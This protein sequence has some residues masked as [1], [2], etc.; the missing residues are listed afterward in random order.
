MRDY[1]N[2]GLFAKWLARALE[3]RGRVEE[4]RRW[5]AR[6]FLYFEL[7][8]VPD[9]V[10]GDRARFSALERGVTVFVG[11]ERPFR[12]PR[13]KYEPAQGAYLGFYAEGEPVLKRLG[14][15]PAYG[16]VGELFGK[17]HA[18]YLIYAHWGQPFPWGDLLEI[19][20]AGGAVQISLEPDGPGGLEAVTDGSWLRQ[21]LEAASSFSFTPI[22]LRFAPE[23][24]GDWVAWH[25]H[26]ELYVE[27]WRLLARLVREVA[28]N[29]ALVWTLFDFTPY[30]GQT[31]LLEVR[32]RSSRGETVSFSARLPVGPQESSFPDLAGHWARD[33]VAGLAREGIVS[34]FEDG[35]YRPGEKVS[36][37]AFFKLLLAAAGRLPQAVAGPH[38]LDVLE[39]HWFYPWADRA[40]AEGLLTP[41][42]YPERKLRPEE[43][44]TRAEAALA[45]VRLMDMKARPDLSPRFLDSASLSAEA[46]AAVLAV[47]EA[48]IMG[49]YPDGTFRPG[50]AITR[51]EAAAVVQ[52]IRE[53]LL[54][55]Q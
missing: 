18:L 44:I 25:G 14:R 54:T 15:P 38:F 47:A 12:G 55:G 39:D 29:V 33:L 24:N 31:V 49:G 52:R 11:R 2:A 23:M 27:K 10:E 26:P 3:E 5:Y 16:K 50:G 22:F 4:A 1:K 6:E 46:K 36:R 48:G 28:P 19:V 51:A 34:G 53:R 41:A 13:A 20:S 37:A 43:P 21:W 7:A 17:K 32:A 42:A 35:T 40:V 30:R 45:V 8:G 9:W